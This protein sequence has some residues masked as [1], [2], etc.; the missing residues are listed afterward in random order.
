M[1]RNFVE[2]S[3]FEIDKTLKYTWLQAMLSYRKYVSSIIKY[4]MWLLNLVW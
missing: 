4:Q 1:H 3:L 2:I